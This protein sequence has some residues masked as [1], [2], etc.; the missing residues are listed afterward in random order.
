MTEEKRSTELTVAALE[1]VMVTGDLS[2]LSPADRLKYY[3]SV[4]R[5]LGLN[6]LTGP[7]QYI[8]LSGRLTL[9][10]KRDATDQLRK[11]NKVSITKL[12]REKLDDVYVVTA[13]ATTADGR[14]DE[15]I[16]AVSLKGLAGEALANA[17]MKAETK[18]KRR[19]TLSIVGLGMLDETE[20]ET[21][22]D[23]QQANVNTT[24]GEMSQPARLPQPK[25]VP[26]E[27]EPTQPDNGKSKS[28]LAKAMEDR[29]RELVDKADLLD[30]PAKGFNPKWTQDEFLEAGKELRKA[31]REVEEKQAALGKPAEAKQAEEAPF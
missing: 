8:T 3:E 15:S 14:S 22:P 31:V 4:C 26:H 30:I 17:L 24:T 18:A 20:I 5:S 2:K 11:I 21:I 27:P 16:G 9:Y 12:V 13:S 6:P 23:A 25:T 19:V 10:A 28:G 1:Q 7:F 29:Y